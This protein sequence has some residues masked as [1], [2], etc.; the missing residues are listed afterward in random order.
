MG[1]FFMVEGTM[2]MLELVSRFKKKL[3]IFQRPSI[4]G[5]W[6]TFDELDN[7]EKYYFTIVR[8]NHSY[9]GIV[10]KYLSLKNQNKF[11]SIVNAIE[12]LW[13]VEL[14]A[15]GSYCGYLQ[16]PETC[17]VYSVTLT[18]INDG[19]KLMVKGQV[20]STKHIRTQYWNRQIS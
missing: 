9:F 8:N 12:Y 13:G 6:I 4:E 11:S 20:G 10:T 17:L 14:N 1:C 18:L 7:E 5:D 19:C 16:D 2:A 15:D 3:N